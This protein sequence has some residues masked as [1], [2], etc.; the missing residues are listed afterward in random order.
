MT[1]TAFTRVE[2]SP[3]LHPQRSKRVTVLPGTIHPSM[4]RPRIVPTH[5]P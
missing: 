4:P 5:L 1:V 2:L 3:Q